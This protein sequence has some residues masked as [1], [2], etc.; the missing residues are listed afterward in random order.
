MRSGELCSNDCLK[1]AVISLPAT[2]RMNGN[3]LQ[4][5]EEHV[6]SRRKHTKI[7]LQGVIGL[8]NK[9]GERERERDRAAE[10]VFA[11]KTTKT[12]YVRQ[13]SGSSFFRTMPTPL[14]VRFLTIIISAAEY[15]MI[16]FHANRGVYIYRSITYDTAL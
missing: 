4:S 14:V 12:T 3:A 8:Q 10:Y 6:G 1:M 5:F 9:G 7:T 13:V 2:A 11:R 16:R 15:G